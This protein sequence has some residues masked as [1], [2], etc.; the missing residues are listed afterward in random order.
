MV[1]G[2]AEFNILAYGKARTGEMY[3][4]GVN[5]FN[6]FHPDEIVDNPNVPEIV[7]TDFQIFNRPVSIAEEGSPLKKPVSESEAIALSHKE[8]VFSFEFAALDY[9]A[10]EKN[11]FAYMMEGFDPDWNYVGTRRFA[12]Y[13]NLDPGRYVFRV[14]GSNNDGVWNEEGRSLAI[15]IHPPP[16]RTWWAYTLYVALMGAALY[17][18]RAYELNR[19]HLR[20]QLEMEQLESEKLRELDQVKS[21]FFA[22]I[23]HEF[24]TPLTLIR[25]TRESTAIRNHRGGHPPRSRPR[26]EE[27]H[28]GCPVSSHSSWTSPASR[29][30]SSE[31]RPGR[32]ISSSF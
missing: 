26:L 20:N 24:R 17:G 1:L 23:S 10:P 27:T 29:R 2:A 31:S 13:T 30:E 6:V 4:G 11:Q 28:R 7:I 32:P 9:T 15:V 25:G 8:T 19:F 22:N 5:G 14:K 12:N 21:H 3:F 18:V 16:W